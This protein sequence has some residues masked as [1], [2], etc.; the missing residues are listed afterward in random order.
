MGIE[1]CKIEQIVRL[2]K[3]SSDGRDRPMLVKMSS[4][5]EKWTI[6]GRA[7]RLM[8]SNE[9]MR[10]VYINRDMTK[11]E[12]AMEYHLRVMLAEKRGRGEQNWKIRRGKLVDDV[13]GL[14]ESVGEVEGTSQLDGRGEN[15]RERVD[16][17]FRRGGGEGR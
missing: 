7:K 9:Q 10:K 3:Q 12:R 6:L 1:E 2:G 4:E 8:N 14:E 15:G 16:R 17:N 11:E 13:R 5:R